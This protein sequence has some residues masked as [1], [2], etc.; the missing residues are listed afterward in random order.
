LSEEISSLPPQLQDQI[1][2]LQELQ[3]TLQMVVEAKTQLE[4]EL[5]E[6]NRALEELEKMADDA[7]V[8]KSIGALLIKTN[9]KSVLT[10]LNERKELVNTRITVLTKQ[11]E[12]SRQK[13][14]ELQE[15]VQAG[16]KG[17]NVPA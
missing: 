10:E 12:R 3:R 2:R 13:V 15:K 1:M 11:E 6:T 7:L 4:L 16:L 14:K 8:Y 9:K 17:T 5:A